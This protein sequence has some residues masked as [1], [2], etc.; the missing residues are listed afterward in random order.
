MTRPKSHSRVHDDVEY[1]PLRPS[2]APNTKRCCRLLTAPL[3]FYRVPIQFVPFSR[4]G[5]VRGKNDDTVA[6]YR[7]HGRTTD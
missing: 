2:R 5:N 4:T 1:I 3:T 6:I 7:R